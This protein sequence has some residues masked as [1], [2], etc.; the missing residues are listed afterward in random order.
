MTLTNYW[1]L[2]IWLFIA[3]PI[4]Y[5]IFPQ[6]HETIMGKK[7][8]RWQ[9]LPAVILAVPYMV[10]AGF[11]S[12]AFGDTGVYR[13]GFADA[14]TTFGGLFAYA[15]SATKDKGFSFL[16]GLIKCIFGQSDTLYFLILAVIQLGILIA[17][18]RKYSSSLWLSLFLF[19][20]STDYMS[21]MQ[22]GIRQFT[23]VT[24]ILTATP[25]MVEKKYIRAALLILLA[26]T[27]HQSALLMLIF[28]LIAQGKAW[29]K[30]TLLFIA[31][32]LL[33]IVFVDR[34][35]GILDNMMQETQYAN[36]VNDWTS[37]Q[38]DGTNPIRVFV[39]SIP[40]ILSLIGLKY[41]RQADNP[42]INFCTNMSI[43]SMGIYLVSM[44]TSGIFIGR[45]PIYASLYG[46]ILLPWE[47]EE[48]FTK[49]SARMVMG[50]AV[51]GYC[52]F[53]YY[54]MHF[55]WGCM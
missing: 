16:T 54:Q 3:G 12:D 35:T 40:A 52:M 29:N 34:F 19:V 18:Y 44:A 43:I 21:W 30:R 6:K 27:M 32:A 26:A 13:S 48:M 7:E 15:G 14:P 31:A 49:E 2:L 11:R 20:A 28:M 47:I 17:L 42:V 50:A 38:D 51:L 25:F 4:L 23:A 24:I 10:W 41:I 55:T 45:L 9:M 33:A 8:V 46:Y 1:W 36:M 22:N 53:F 37:W 39:Y 5:Y